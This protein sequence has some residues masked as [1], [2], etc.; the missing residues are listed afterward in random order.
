M[1]W[2]TFGDTGLDPAEVAPFESEETRELREMI[3]RNEQAAYEAR[4]RMELGLDT[5]GD[6]A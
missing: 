5:E 3:E 4:V 6:A 1:S 2:G